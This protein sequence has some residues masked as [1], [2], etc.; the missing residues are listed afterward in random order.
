MH[1]VTRAVYQLYLEQ[2]HQDTCNINRCDWNIAWIDRYGMNFLRTLQKHQ[3][4]NYIPGIELLSK[5][6]NFVRIVHYLT[7][8]LQHHY[9]FVPLSW[10]LP[11]MYREFV[12]YHTVMSDMESTSSQDAQKPTYIVKPGASCQGSGI[13]L[14][15]NPKDLRTR[16]PSTSIVVSKYIDNPL[17]IQNFKFD[18]RIYV[19]VTSSNP[20]RIYVFEE[21]LAR[22]CT[23]T[24][25]FPCASNLQSIYAHLTNYTINKTNRAGCGGEK[26]S[27]NTDNFKWSLSQLNEY[28]VAEYG[29]RV[30]AG[31]WDRIHVII[32]STV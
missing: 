15:Q 27:Q 29:A 25:E 17:L 32:V 11:R 2:Y 12:Q 9:A 24:Y 18:L 31:V 20:P 8:R 10:D 5:K 1:A 22:F 13:Y 19:L 21:G 23:Q 4:I 14:I 28:L 7:S 26:K 3:K 6:K 16:H 30:C